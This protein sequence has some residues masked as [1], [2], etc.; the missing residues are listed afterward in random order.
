MKF[1][2]K[3]SRNEESVMSKSV[4]KKRRF[5]VFD[6]SSITK[7]LVMCSLEAYCV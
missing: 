6:G 5:C 2:F 7:G 3:R 4:G 1:I